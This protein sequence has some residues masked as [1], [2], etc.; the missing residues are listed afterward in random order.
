MKIGG[1]GSDLFQRGY[2]CGASCFAM[3]MELSASGTQLRV[4]SEAATQRIGNVLYSTRWMFGCF[5]RVLFGESVLAM[6]HAA[7][8]T[9]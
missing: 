5:E 7:R 9:C 2:S 3:D 4:Y 1:I 6:F 8:W